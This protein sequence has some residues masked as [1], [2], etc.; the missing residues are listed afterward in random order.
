MRRWVTLW[1]VVAAVLTASACSGD[2][3]DPGADGSP[4]TSDSGSPTPARPVVPPAPRE[5]A[6]YRLEL[7]QLTEPTNES[8]P[9]RCAKQHTAQTIHVGRLRLVVDGHAIAVDSPRVRQQVATDCPR[10]LASYVGGDD[11]DRALSRFRVVWFSPTL[12]QA[13]AGAR[14]FRCDL[15]SFGRGDD[16]QRQEGTVPKGIL[17][18][19][20]GL[21][22]FGLCGTAEPGSPGFE[23][24]L[25]SLPHTWQA[26]ATIGLAGG[27]AY[28]GEDAVRDEGDGDCQDRVRALE[29]FA[30]TFTY[31][32][33][34]PTKAQWRAG[35]R[36]GYCWAESGG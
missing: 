6:C 5:G 14:W 2:T 27:E 11:Q 36:F 1:L 17:G 32:W 18:R 28:P 4:T 16:L 31:G 21:D 23:R 22:L 26:I 19:S 3:D 24:V 30:L 8:K 20:D 7:D 35:Q 33:E 34:W 13:D 9:V 29:N 12:E 10:R 15:V 25:C